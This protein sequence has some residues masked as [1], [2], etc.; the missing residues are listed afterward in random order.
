M[1]DDDDKQ[2]LLDLDDQ[3]LIF[4]LR[5]DRIRIRLA[6][7]VVTNKW[8]EGAHQQSYYEINI[9]HFNTIFTKEM[10][11]AKTTFKTIAVN[12]QSA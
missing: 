11:L 1:N 12:L 6:N 2:G 4:R 8:E 10:N 7:Q 3:R 9:S 5:I